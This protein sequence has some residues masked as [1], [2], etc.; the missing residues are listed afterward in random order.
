MLRVR[1]GETYTGVE[2][3][4][5]RK[6]GV[7]IEVEVSAAPIRDASGSVVSHMA[8]FA[9]DRRWSFGHV[10][11]DEAQELTA[12]MWRLLLRRCPGRSFTVVG[13]IVAGR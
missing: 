6:D 10:I 9:D 13:D 5:V 1:G 11:V 2:T 8:L 7:P 4:R 3:T 12:M